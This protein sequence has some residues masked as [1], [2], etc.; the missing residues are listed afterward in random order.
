MKIK[1][2]VVSS[3]LAGSL[4][5][6]F[7]GGAGAAAEPNAGIRNCQGV[8]LSTFASTQGGVGNKGFDVQVAQQEV[9]EICDRLQGQQP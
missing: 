3:L 7:V 4:L 1:R 8:F 2:F 5:V 6:A 9:R